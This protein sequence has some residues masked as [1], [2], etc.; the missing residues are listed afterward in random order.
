MAGEV[1]VNMPNRDRIEP[2]AGQST[3]VSYDMKYH[4]DVSLD[5]KRGTQTRPDAPTEEDLKTLRRVSDR[6]PFKIFT[7]A[8]VELCERFSYYG[9]IIVVS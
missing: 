3:E 6:I 1:A 5:E 7:I 8:F 4:E 9:S 2:S